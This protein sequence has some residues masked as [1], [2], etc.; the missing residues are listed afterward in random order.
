MRLRAIRRN[1]EA[2]LAFVRDFWRD[3][4]YSPSIKEIGTATNITSSS[5]V[6]YGLRTLAQRRLIR[7]TPHV[8]RS[9]VITDPNHRCEMCG[10][11][12]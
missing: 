4:G 9:I 1:E 10:A 3:N 7:Y 5:V 12:I 6:A 11:P 8:S 2:I